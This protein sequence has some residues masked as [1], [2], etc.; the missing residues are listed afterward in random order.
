MSE[1]SRIKEVPPVLHIS[2]FMHGHGYLE[3]AKNLIEKIPKT[4]D[5]TFE[6]S[7]LSFEEKWQRAQDRGHNI[8]DR[9]KLKKQIEEAATLGKLAYLVKDIHQSNQ[10]NGSQGRNDVKVINMVNDGRNRFSGETYHPLGMTDLRITMGEAGRNK[11]V[12][13]E[14][15][16]VKC[17][18][19]YNILM[20]RTEMRSLRAVGSSIHPL[21]KFTTDQGLIT[22]KT[23]K[24][25]MWEC[26]QLEETQNSWKETQWR[27]HM[28]QMSKIREQAIFTLSPGCK[29]RLI[30]ILRKNVD[31]LA[32]AGSEG[33]TV[34]RFVMEHQLKA[35][36][37][38]ESVVHK[39]RPLTPDKRQALKEKVKDEL[40]S[41]MGYLY[42]C[43]LR[44]PKES[45]EVRMV[46]D[47]EEKTR[48]HTEEGEGFGLHRNKRGNKARPSK[49]TRDNEKPH[50]KRP[51]PDTT[52]VR[53]DKFIPKLAELMLPIRKVCRN[54]DMAEGPSWTRKAEEAIQKIK[55]KLQ[56][57]QTLTM[58][59]EGEVPILCLQQKSKTINSMLLMERGRVQIPISY[60]SRPLQDIKAC[61]TSTEKTILALIHTA[62]RDKNIQHLIRPNQRGRRT[63][64]EQIP[65]IEGTPVTYVERKRGRGTQIK[66]R[67]LSRTNLNAKG[68]EV[69]LM[70]KSRQRSMDYEALLA[71]LVTSAGKSMKDLHVF[72]DLKIL[73]DHVE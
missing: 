67:T 27:Q 7:E 37:L 49:I 30:N 73:V 25:A 14:F 39:K 51:R 65:Q 62:Y 56:K 32:W 45:S 1:S 50:P 4:V 52:P 15:A 21:I 38:A 28:E 20:G 19:P 42:K 64:S 17:H 35:Y 36:P 9:Y 71:G 13:M 41:L 68:M 33:T 40:A 55:I 46:E 24:E 31:V 16:I 63:D 69:I 29:Q 48:F 70:K 10:R 72:V 12:L 44:L 58:P 2:A 6:G 11:T 22:M 53:I 54:I 43:F 18:S 3:L 34:P 66:Q 57:L 8:N 47:D 59:K 26:R 60:V 23:S 61:Y 5:E